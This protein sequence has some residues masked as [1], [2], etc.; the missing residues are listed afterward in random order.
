MQFSSLLRSCSVSSVSF[1]AG[2]KETQKNWISH[3]WVFVVLKWGHNIRR[4]AN[5]HPFNAQCPFNF[6]KKWN[7]NCESSLS[8]TWQL[9]KNSTHFHNKQTFTSA[10][11][12]INEFNHFFCLFSDPP[13]GWA[14][15]I[16]TIFF[17][18]FFTAWFLS[19]PVQEFHRSNTKFLNVIILLWIRDNK[20]NF[21]LSV[22]PAC[23]SNLLS[24][25]WW[26]WWW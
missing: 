14:P 11:T 18:H 25:W 9:Y 7:L 3:R 10:A 15:R 20:T 19:Q 8:S 5:H 23:F 4:Q 1:H 24:F 21:W 13:P 2:A 6:F 17:P 16:F 22:I 12:S 26:W